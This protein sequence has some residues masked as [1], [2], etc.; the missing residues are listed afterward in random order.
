MV[1]KSKV[2]KKPKKTIR[3]KQTQS[4]K[5][6]VNQIVRIYLDERKKARR[7]KTAPKKNL[8]GVGSSNYFMPSFFPS[9]NPLM[10][11]YPL[12]QPYNSNFYPRPP[13]GPP[14]VRNRPQP[15]AIGAPIQSQEPV[16]IVNPTPPQR[17]IPPAPPSSPVARPQPVIP[18]NI[19]VPTNPLVAPLKPINN[20]PNLQN[21]NADDA[22][23]FMD[24]TNSVVGVADTPLPF[25]DETNDDVRLANTQLPFMDETNDD[26]RLAN[27][28]L[29]FM[30]ETIDDVRLADENDKDIGK[31]GIIK[32]STT[33]ITNTADQETLRIPGID[34]LPINR[35][36]QTQLPFY[37]QD[38]IEDELAMD[39]NMGLG[40][41]SL[42]RPAETKYELLPSMEAEDRGAEERF[43]QDDL[44][45]IKRYDALRGDTRG[46]RPQT[47]EGYKKAIE[48]MVKSKRN[49]EIP[50]MEGRTRGE[51]ATL[52]T[53]PFK[54]GLSER[55]RTPMGK[56]PAQ[57]KQAVVGQ[58][59]KIG[60]KINLSSK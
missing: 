31:S 34:P 17:V 26:V 43:S 44:A 36:L 50:I 5:Q 57:R 30:D 51:T 22:L 6:N 37:T 46:R 33:F 15:P 18:A 38:P 1:V 52:T 58:A 24:E 12:Q 40:Y 48:R 13:V 55:E 8:K 19:N 32:P 14:P 59:T 60:R 49:D 25:M 10:N 9:Q 11:T 28:P 42:E 2:K 29:P 53:T 45:I 21:D 39:F 4:Q 54:T 23:P 41:S 47:I 3:Q 20:F 16:P 27:T 7:K 56:S 35:P